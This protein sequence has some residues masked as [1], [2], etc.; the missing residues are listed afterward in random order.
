M[1]AARMNH[2]AIV[3][4]GS[5]V[6]LFRIRG[7][8]AERRETSAQSNARETTRPRVIVNPWNAHRGC[9]RGCYRK[10]VYVCVPANDSSVCFQ[11]SICGKYMRV[12]QC[13]R[14]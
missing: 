3:L 14:L 2:V 11:Q 8:I 12:S 1:A 9:R 4:K 5:N 7:G 10:R 6:A 13:S